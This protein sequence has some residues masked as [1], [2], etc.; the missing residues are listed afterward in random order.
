[1]TSSP[2]LPRSAPTDNALAGIANVT[3][4]FFLFG[5]TSALAKIVLP[6]Y[7]V[8]QMMLIRSAVALVIFLPFIVRAGITPFHFMPRPKLQLVRTTLSVIEVGM[9]FWSV[10]YLPIADTVAIYLSG[11]IFV[12]L[13]STL[14]LGERVGWRRWS[15]IVIG[16]CGVLV[17]LRPS[18]ATISLP[19]M[20][21]VVG[22]M[23]YAIGVIATR[24][25]RGTADIVLSANQ[26]A[27]AV[28]F[29]A[30]WCLLPGGWTTPTQSDLALLLFLGVPTA[31]GYVCMNRAIKL[32]PASVVAPFQYTLILWAALFGYLFFGDVPA[33]TTIAGATIIVCAGLYISWRERV[34]GKE[35][36]PVVDPV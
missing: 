22:T 20:I 19:A 29:G 34:L 13:W 10:S 17:A 26:M 7:S 23:L 36:P 6:S 4:A 21:A 25:L 14:F 11:P 1:M 27:G 5:L 12:T 2:S 9:F 24:T 15:A 3:L 8:G 18:A 28:V 35:P 30:I 31:I 32:A 16:F 33:L